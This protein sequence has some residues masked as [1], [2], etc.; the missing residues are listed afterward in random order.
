MIRLNPLFDLDLPVVPISLAIVIC[1]AAIVA[2][3][4]TGE[5]SYET[6]ANRMPGWLEVAY[7][8]AVAALCGAFLCPW[9]ALPIV[10]AWLA[11]RKA[12]RAR[13]RKRYAYC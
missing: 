3:M 7:V 12:G 1:Y 6:V 10:A 9:A 13:A 11:S 8:L 4:M 2:L 5:L